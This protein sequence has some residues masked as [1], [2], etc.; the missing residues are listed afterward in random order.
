MYYQNKIT[1]MF[2]IE[3]PLTV[4]EKIRQLHHTLSLWYQ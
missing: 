3:I 2:I 1:E 4:N